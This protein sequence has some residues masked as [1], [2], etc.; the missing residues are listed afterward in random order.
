MARASASRLIQ[1][2]R[3]GS[4]ASLIAFLSFLFLVSPCEAQVGY[5]GRGSDGSLGGDMYYGGFPDDFI[6][7][8][9][10]E[11]FAEFAR[12]D[13]EAMSKALDKGSKEDFEKNVAEIEKLDESA[14]S[15]WKLR[16]HDWQ[17]Y[18]EQH[19]DAVKRFESGKVLDED[20]DVIKRYK[21][22]TARKKQALEDTNNINKLK[23]LAQHSWKEWTELWERKKAWEKEH[24]GQDMLA[25]RGWDGKLGGEA[26]DKTEA[27]TDKPTH[28]ESKK[29]KSAGK[30]RSGEPKEQTSVDPATIELGVGIAAALLGSRGDH[31][32]EHS[33]QDRGASSSG[34]AKK[35]KTMTSSQKSG[36]GAA[37]KSGP[38]PR[39]GTTSSGS[40][41]ATMNTT[42]G[43]PTISFGRGF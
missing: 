16:F 6:G 17:E 26:A 32:R 30:K 19:A 22:I 31:R 2:A 9:E 18:R 40:G 20:V 1:D 11:D 29:S 8:I 38:A 14:E 7:G 24:P 23:K 28:T 13:W 37:V 43:A 27:K 3:F 25:R 10:S 33:M 39:G 41:G 42:V 35:A 15:R 5:D 34:R 12:K 36:T 4:G 21:E